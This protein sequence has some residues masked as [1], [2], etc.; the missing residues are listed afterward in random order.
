MN[1]SVRLLSR[2][3]EEKTRCAT[4]RRPRTDRNFFPKPTS[5]ARCRVSVIRSYQTGNSEIGSI[6]FWRIANLL[7]L[8]LP[9]FGH[10][11]TMPRL[12]ARQPARRIAADGRL[13]DRGRGLI[14]IQAAAD[15][16]FRGAHTNPPRALDPED[17]ARRGSACLI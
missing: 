10:W 13:G 7:V 15:G 12:Q 8:A 6:V 1:V 4:R 3:R 14:A 16:K 9:F 17:E 5:R 2:R 11:P